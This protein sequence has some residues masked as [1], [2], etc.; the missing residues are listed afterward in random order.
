MLA[1]SPSLAL[2]INILGQP[3]GGEF[4]T[5]F[6]IR[7]LRVI[8]HKSEA[9]RNAD[10]R[11]HADCRRDGANGAADC[12]EGLIVGHCERGYSDNVAPS[13]S[14]RDCPA[15]ERKCAMNWATGGVASFDTVRQMRSGNG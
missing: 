5:I 8:C 12:G 7:D 11:N 3:F 1:V 6:E 9:H 2:N 15:V 4:G 10:A 13:D 14:I